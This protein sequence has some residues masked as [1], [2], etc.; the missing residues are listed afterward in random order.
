[1]GV[2]IVAGTDGTHEDQFRMQDELTALVRVGLSPIAAIKPATP[3]AAECL[4]LDKRTGAIKP[5][6]EADLIVVEGDPTHNIEGEAIELARTGGIRFSCAIRVVCRKVRGTPGQ[7]P[8]ARG[9][10]RAPAPA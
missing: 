4:T 10:P 1:M 6:L 5:G 8:S 7:G 2:R 9:S 3:V